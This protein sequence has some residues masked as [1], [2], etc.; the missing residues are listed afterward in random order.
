MRIG[1]DIGGTH[2]DGVLIDGERLIAAAKA[3]TL[4]DNLLESISQVLN[5]I[6]LNQDPKAVR[7]LNLSTTLNTNAIVTGNIDP[8]G[9]LVV[10]GPGIAPE[11]YRVGDHYHLIP[12]SLDHLGTET[13]PLDLEA[14]QAAF[15]DCFEKGVKTFAVVAKFSPRN[16]VFENTIR[17]YLQERADFIS[18]GHLISGQLNFG[19]RIHTAYY[20]SAVWRN[21]HTFSTA[22]MESLRGFNIQAEV[23]I[24]KADGGTMP[25]SRALETPVQSIFSGP[26]ASVMGILA[27]TRTSSDALILDIGGTTTDVAIFAGGQPLLEREGISIEG[28]PT[29]V[30]AMHVE[31]IGIGGDSLLQV[32]QDQVLVGPK[33]IGPCM[34]RGG[35]S[36]TL[37]D[38]FNVL[39]LAAFGDEQR[40][41]EGVEAL[42]VAHGMTGMQLAAKAMDV[43]INAISAKI[44][45]LIA[46]VNSRPVYTIHEILEDRPIFP[47]QLIM[48]GGPAAVFK[49]LLQTRLG[50]EVVVPPLYEVANAIGAAL[51]RSTSYLDLTADTVKG[52]LS[53]PRLAI[54]RSVPR[55]YDLEAATS[56]ARSLLIDDLEQAGVSISA[57]EVQITQADSFNVVED[58]YTA[59][60]NI[61]VVSQV[62]PAVIAHI[63]TGNTGIRV[64]SRP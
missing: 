58:F 45:D 24:L 16:P 2:T 33:R 22:L 15:T 62:Q 30:R 11:T 51:T 56:E 47:T 8:V 50:M 23:N 17:G 38:A 64:N 36:P 52:M 18:S 28:R 43:A 34:A 53:V 57:D 31:S 63:D 7:T 29:L 60:R 26:A 1:I 46:L 14:L 6:L 9:V 35:F 27:I 41:A 5:S 44:E 49:E 42:A 25:M 10:G 21:F 19:R 39:K 3:P 13:A 55:N 12:G 40:S 61:R 4:Y 32:E 37:M 59:G 20:N 48:I 54:Y